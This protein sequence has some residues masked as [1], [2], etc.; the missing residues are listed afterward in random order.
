MKALVLHGKH[1]IQIEH[2]FPEPPLGPDCIKIAVS[3]CG[4]CG[5][6]IHK[7]E[8]KGGSRPV[9]YPVPLG[10]EASGI[11]VETGK[12]V[13]DLKAGDRVAVDPNWYCKSCWF[14]Q[15]GL[16]HFCENSRGVVKGF[17]E[18]ICPPRE[19][20][21]KLP[22]SLSLRDAA[23]AEPLSCCLH[24]MDLL[25]LKTGQTVVI[26]GLGSIG[27]IFLQLC[28]RAGAARCIVVEPQEQKRD[29]AMRLGASLFLNPEKVHVAEE[30]RRAGIPNVDRVIECVGLKSTMASALEIA[31]KGA[32][33]LLFGLGEAGDPMPFD[34]YAAF[35]KELTVKTSFINPSSMGRALALL[36]TGVIEVEPLIS[37]VLN[38]EEMA[39]ELKNRTLFRKGKVLLKVFGEGA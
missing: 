36:E 31:G 37:G 10:H 6:D 16:T 7:Y 29:L 27:S 20:V 13:R 11:V 33:V 5:T 30:I 22:D 35:Q 19:N 15:N 24:G 26:I 39:E 38:M 14:C 32:A 18:Y 2:D 12:Q 28:R 3:Y 23:L 21:Y 4:L 8:G 25:D 34:Q 9:V 17:A 1:Q